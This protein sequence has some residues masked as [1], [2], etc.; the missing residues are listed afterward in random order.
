MMHAIT[1]RIV[2]YIINTNLCAIYIAIHDNVYNH[3]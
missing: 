2:L 3:M 1:Y